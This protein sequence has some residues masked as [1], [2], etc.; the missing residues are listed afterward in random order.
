M[1][2]DPCI[3]TQAS[4][5]FA[6]LNTASINDVVGIVRAV[7]ED[8]NNELTY[9]M[10]TSAKFSISSEAE[11]DN[12]SKVGQISVK[13]ALST[14]TYT[15]NVK[16]TEAGGG[17]AT[18]EV[19][20]K[21]WPLPDADADGLIEVSTL[22]QLSAIRYDLNGD[23]TADDVSS[24][25]AYQAAFLGATGSYNGYELMVNLDFEVAGSYASNTI[26]TIWTTGSGWLPIGYYNSFDNRSFSTT[27]EGNGHT[28]SNLFIRSL[29]RDV[30]LFGYVSGSSELRNIGLL[31]VK[32]SGNINVGGL[33]GRNYQGTVS[34]SYAT[35]SV[36]AEDSVGGLVGQNY[37][38]KVSNSYATGSVT[39]TRD[40]LGGLVGD[41]YRGTVSGSY[42]TG[43][44]T[45]DD[46]LGGL[47]GRN[48]QGTVSNSYA[49]GSVTGND[50]LGGL[51]GFSSTGTVTAS[52]YNTETTGQN[53]IGKGEGKT[54]ADLLT[55][56]DY[57]GIY[58]AWDD[59]LDGIANNTDDTDY[60]DFG[61]NDQYPVLKLDVDGNGTVG[62]ATDLRLQ[63]PRLS[64]VSSS[65]DFGEVYIASTASTIRS[66]NLT[67]E[68][69]TGN[70][71]LA[72]GGANA[73][74][75]VANMTTISPS[76]GAVPE[77]T[78]TV[79][80]TPTTA[81][82]P[83]TAMITHSSGGLLQS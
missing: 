80:F 17:T 49:T 23:G 79:T 15:L 82:G 14:N 70:V 45:G 16:V 66:Y 11:M 3:F 38:G 39:G 46:N 30:G 76:N 62:D 27:F 60:W 8:A 63:R 42:A 53:D 54:T 10:D 50:D 58:Q 55:P 26:S 5:P 52:Y 64:V 25:T 74:L 73:D 13:A 37:Q 47:V 22:E 33:V 41:S 40:H 78:V 28:I 12:P 48:Y 44:V 1:H 56:T 36:T 29:S 35:G 57:T 19:R 21:V 20:I 4:Y 34:N 69:L 61:T 43:S 7:P 81:G 24:E 32:V 65:L 77:T 51:V 31:D 67:G 2:R 71:T 18:V 72:I 9:S 75:F 68:N 83:F 59:G 6:I